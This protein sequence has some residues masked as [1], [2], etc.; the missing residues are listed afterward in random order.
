[1]WHDV[2]PKPVYSDN[3]VRD[4]ISGARDAVQRLLAGARTPQESDK[5]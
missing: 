2:P 1:V 5:K 4:V 3:P